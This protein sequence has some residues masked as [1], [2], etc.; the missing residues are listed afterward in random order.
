M[1]IDNRVLQKMAAYIRS[2]FYALILLLKCLKELSASDIEV[3]LH[4][5]KDDLP[6]SHEDEAYQYLKLHCTLN[7]AVIPNVVHEML[8]CQRAKGDNKGH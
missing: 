8:L 1:R 3:S 5:V 4:K 2:E 7:E 6:N